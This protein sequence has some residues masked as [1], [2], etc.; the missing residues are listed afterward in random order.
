MNIVKYIILSGLLAC[1]LSCANK[2]LYQVED[3]NSQKSS[4]LNKEISLVGVIHLKNSGVFI[5]P[6]K[7]NE[8]C[9]AIEATKKIYVD[10]AALEGE[11]IQLKGKYVDHEFTEDGVGFLPSRFVV[12]MI[13]KE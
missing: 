10:I 1:I 3:V 4:L 6:E 8:K 2:S 11:L 13:I 12:S 5:C 9:I 7:R